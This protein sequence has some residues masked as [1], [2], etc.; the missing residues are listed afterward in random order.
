MTVTASEEGA[1]LLSFL[2]RH[3]PQAPSVKAIKRAIDGKYCR[4]NGR[5][6]TFSSHPLRKGDR[7][8]LDLSGVLLQKKTQQPL[9][10][11]LFEDEVLLICNKPPG[12]VCDNAS[13][14]Q[15]LPQHLGNLQL[16]HRLDKETSGA[17]M[18][19]KEPAMKE[20]MIAL[21]KEHQVHK[22]YLALVDGAVKQ[23]SGKIDNYLGKK[24][25]YQGQTIYGVVTPGKG[26]RAVTLWK[27]LK[28]GPTSTLL[29]AEPVTGRTHQL[30]VHF[31]HIGH[32]ILGDYQYG[33]AF[34]CKLDPKRHLLHAYSIRFTHPL[35][36]Q[37]IEVI[38]PAPSDFKSA[39]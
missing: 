14:N 18:I 3:C 12:L 37:E 2:R 1:T 4:V 20:K 11:V 27:C 16:I 15:A 10:K 23:K 21:F 6:E 22:Q 31:S 25:S 17:L 39:L 26:E 28:K 36:H 9:L 24:G 33:K 13:I 8:H 35:S 5:V 38:A 32:P 29:L 30:R 34:K 19:A 7:V